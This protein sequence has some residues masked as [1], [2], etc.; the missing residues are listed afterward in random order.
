MMAILRMAWAV[1]EVLT[2]KGVSYLNPEIRL[3]MSRGR[4]P[5][6]RGCVP[7]FAVRKI[8]E[9]RVFFILQERSYS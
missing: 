6:A 5:D 2:A 3:D 8:G 1:F 7:A 9:V 4:L